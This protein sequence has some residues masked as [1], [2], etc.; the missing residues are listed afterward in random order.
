MA[1]V[2]A[3]YWY[4]V[5]VAV[6]A[7]LVVYVVINVA[8]L[9]LLVVV[10]AKGVRALVHK[11]RR[12]RG[13]RGWR[14]RR[15]AHRRWFQGVGQRARRSEARRR[16][17]VLGCPQAVLRQRAPWRTD[18]ASTV[19]RHMSD[20]GP[21]SLACHGCGALYRASVCRRGGGCPAIGRPIFVAA[22][23]PLP[24]HFPNSLTSQGTNSSHADL[25]RSACCPRWLRPRQD[26]GGPRDARYRCASQG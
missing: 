8:G 17:L 21:A 4:G 20:N 10:V 13:G 3:G 18:T 25:P 7:G 14:R 15:G 23:A 11:R 1:V 9:A 16:A 19:V 6:V 22:A 2:F 26:R 24:Y 5:E 12:R